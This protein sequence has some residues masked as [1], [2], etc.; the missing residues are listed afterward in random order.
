MIKN[1]ISVAKSKKDKIYATDNKGNAMFPQNPQ[2]AELLKA[3]AFAN[4][5]E[6]E[7]TQTLNDAGELVNLE[8]PVREFIITAVFADRQAAVAANA[9][10]QIFELES[11]AYAQSQVA[12]LAKKYELDPKTLASTI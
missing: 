6:R 8:H 1:L 4:V 3:G 10:E 12:E 5:I 7:R 2:V 9:E 11:K